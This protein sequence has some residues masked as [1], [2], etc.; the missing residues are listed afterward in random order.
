MDAA[1]AKFEGGDE[2]FGSNASRPCE[3]YCF[4]YPSD[5]VGGYVD[6]SNGRDGVVSI[7][8]EV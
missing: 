3:A 4:M 5:G 2:G 7:D 6:R 8:G 1:F